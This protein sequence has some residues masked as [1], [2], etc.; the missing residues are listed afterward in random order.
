MSSC[1]TAI[2]KNL[3]MYLKTKSL[4]SENMFKRGTKEVDDMF[5]DL[6]SVF[7]RY[8]DQA[9]DTDKQTL[10]SILDLI[11]LVSEQVHSSHRQAESTIGDFKI[12][13]TALEGSY[14][15]VDGDFDKTVAQPAEKEA[16]EKDEEEEERAKAIEEYTKRGRP[17]FYE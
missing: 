1:D 4:T 17:K 15:N 16:K 6:L 5:M 7:Q 14:K 8:Y 2:L 13:V 12:Y 11:I 10:R 3:M 9:P